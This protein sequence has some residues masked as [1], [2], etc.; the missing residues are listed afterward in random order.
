MRWYSAFRLVPAT[1]FFFARLG[2]NFAVV[3]HGLLTG[4]VACG[5]Y[6]VLTWWDRWNVRPLRLKHWRQNACSSTRSSPGRSRVTFNVLDLA[7]CL[8]VSYACSS[9][10]ASGVSSSH[11]A[12]MRPDR[13]G[14]LTHPSPTFFP[15]VNDVKMT[16]GAACVFTVR[17]ISRTES[18]DSIRPLLTRPDRG[19]PTSSW[20]VDPCRQRI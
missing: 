20:L 1:F 19:R 9:Q 16:C 11:Q 8:W 12:V 2:I 10:Q 4:L 7:D 13:R 14:L 5:N 17:L 18:N 6:L 3:Q 15:F